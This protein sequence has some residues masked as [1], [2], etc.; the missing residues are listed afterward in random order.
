MMGFNS[1]HAHLRLAPP[2]GGG[3]IACNAIRVRGSLRE[4][5]SRLCAL[6]EAPHP[7][8]LPVRTGRRGTP[9]RRR[10]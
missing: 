1:F 7:N 9:P 5:L 8:L 10:T 6:I 2:A 3:R 4:F